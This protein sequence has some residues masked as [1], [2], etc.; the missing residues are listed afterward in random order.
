MQSSILRW[1]AVILL[2]ATASIHIIFGAIALP[3]QF[4]P[5]FY[6][7]GSIYLVG[8]GALAAK[9]RPKL[10]QLL[11][12][13]YTVLIIAI[14]VVSGQARIPV[15]YLDKTIEVVLVINLL[16]LIRGKVAQVKL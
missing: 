12:L 6:L 8:A 10:F 16:V 3:P 7:M 15:A 11:A 14:W 13:I 5:V 2:L 1:L 4:A 9:I